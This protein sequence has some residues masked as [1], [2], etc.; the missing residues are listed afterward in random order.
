MSNGDTLSTAGSLGPAFATARPVGLTV[1]HTYTL[2]LYARWPTV[3]SVPL[4]LRY[5]LGGNRPSQTDALKLSHA[6][7]HGFMVRHPDVQGWYFTC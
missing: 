6:R 5:F 1:R 3:L 7:F 2:T 4:A